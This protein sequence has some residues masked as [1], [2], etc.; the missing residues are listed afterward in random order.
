MSRYFG[1]QSSLACKQW[2]SEKTPPCIDRYRR[3]FLFGWFFFFK[4][5]FFPN[6]VFKQVLSFID[7][8][9]TLEEVQA[10]QDLDPRQF[11]KID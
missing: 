4:S 9:T 10:I 3:G 2:S 1:A 6:T 8:L 11:C 7:V 5:G